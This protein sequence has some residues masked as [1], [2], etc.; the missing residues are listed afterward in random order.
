MKKN[1]ALFL[2]FQ[3]IC[4]L[5][6]LAGCTDG[7][8]S[9]SAPNYETTIS[10]MTTYIQNHMAQN[11]VTGLSIALVD[12]QK[13]VWARGFGYADKEANVLAGADTIY[14]IGS[15]S[16]TFAAMAVM[17][18]VDEGLMDLDQP[19]T[20]Y[21][22]GFY[23]NQRFPESGPITI[24]SMLTHHSGIPGDLFNGDSTEGGPFDYNTWL[25]EYLQNEVTS[26]PVNT[27]YAYSNSAVALLRPVMENV[28]PGGFQAYANDLFDRM[29][30]ASTSYD[31]DERIPLERLSKA[32]SG[33]VLLPLLY[34]NI[35]TAG[36]IRSSVMDMAQYI[37]TI[38]AGG[39]SQG[40]QVISRDSLEEMFTRQNGDVPLDFG[41]PIGLTWF[42]GPPDYYG[43]LRVEHEGAT[44]WFHAMIRILYDHQL[45][46]IVLTNT[47]S[48]VEEIAVKALEYALQEKTGITLPPDPVPP[49]SPPD[50]SW[51]QD[52]LEALAGTYVMDTVG[53]NFGT[54][55][56][57]VEKDGLLVKGEPD[58]WIPRQ[59]GYFS[60]PGD[61][62]SESQRMQY[63]FHT[64]EGRFV[65]SSL[66]KGLE[67][68]HAERYEQG[69]IPDAWVSLQGA[70]TATNINPGSEPRPEKNTLAL[71]V[72]ADNILRLKGTMRGNIPIKPLSDTLAI[73]GGMGRNRGESV[74][75]VTVDGEEQIELWGFRYKR[76]LET[77]ATFEGGTLFRTTGAGGTGRFN[78]VQLSGDWPQM[79]RQYGYLLKDQ[80]SEFYDL[81]VARLMAGG[82]TYEDLRQLGQGLYDKQFAYV[83]ELIDGM[84]ET[85]GMSPEKQ[86]IVAG[87]MG[88]LFG[89]SSMDVWGDYTGQGPLVVGR[90]WD[91]VRGPF[92]GYG[93]FLTVVVY[94]PPTPQNG[95]ADINYVGSISMQTGMNSK[96]IFL[97]LQDGSLS[98]PQVY[99]D[100]PPGSFQL[101]SFL[102]NA[103]SPKEISALFQSTPNNMGLIINGAF[104]TR[105]NS[106]NT[107]SVYEWA[108][109]DMKQRNGKGLLASSNYFIDPSWENLPPV[110]DGLDGGFSKERLANLLVLGEQCKGSIDAPTMMEIFDTTIPQGGPTFPDD[111]PIATVHQIVAVPA[112]STLWLKARDYSGWERMDLKPLF[113][114]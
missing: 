12:G 19:L 34:C 85:S 49:F 63:R 36:S 76:T 74:R 59:N 68:L 104:G 33:G 39:V 56:V 62:P 93:R 81:A 103:S 46:V 113:L 73:V 109:Y 54:V 52:R 65:I 17:R 51:A 57:Q 67:F 13:V 35:A 96:G 79:G 55:L 94:N 43:G 30:M 80:M 5:L 89:C 24:R 99:A 98:E 114:P 110:P 108:T 6:L 4:I 23:I 32:Y 18:L 53:T 78:V 38:H 28:A 50:T 37:K 87:L 58:R 105:L 7:G 15:L 11:Q 97:D 45:G 77:L 100:R 71:E 16:K 29:G 101:F 2:F 42:L 112:H 82:A 91:T 9:S 26:A 83:R 64:V 70:Y 20:T 3:Y 31:L 10:R 61:N 27:V 86:K 111:S 92:D 1:K 66:T 47:P 25:L 106:L 8:G 72:G 90:N 44:T 22:P 102:L 48:D 60:L 75:V 14:E 40:G 107:A 69:T 41:F 21:L 84:A 95:V 88:G